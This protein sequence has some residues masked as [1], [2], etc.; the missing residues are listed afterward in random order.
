MGADLVSIIGTIVGFLGI[1]VSIYLFHHQINKLL[2]KIYN[3]VQSLSQQMQ[4]FNDRSGVVTFDQA[5]EIV[6]MYLVGIEYSLKNHALSYFNGNYKIDFQN[7]NIASI[8]ASMDL[9]ADKVINS[10]RR[11]VAV[12]RLPEGETFKHFFDKLH[13]LNDGLID[14]TKKQGVIY[15]TDKQRVDESA[16]KLADDYAGMVH[17]AINLAKKDIMIELEKQYFVSAKK[18]Q[19]E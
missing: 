1:A 2:L 13:P 16:Q 5:L 4:I 11:Q 15:F 18:S 7:G 9:E 17:V 19:G 14:E 10:C 6:D 12:F 3:T 8:K